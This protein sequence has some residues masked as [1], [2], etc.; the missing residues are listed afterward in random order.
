[1]GV[2]EIERPKR[3]AL[4][5]AVVFALAVFGV[6]RDAIGGGGDDGAD[7]RLQK[8]SVSLKQ[9]N[10]DDTDHAATAELGKAEALRDKAR[11]LM[12]ERRERDVLAQ[13]LDELEGTVSL[14]DAK[15]IAAKAKSARVAAEKKR[16]ELRAEVK[17]I[18]ADAD[19]LEAQQAELEKKLGGGK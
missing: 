1:M 6:G 15:I 13:T 2:H 12:G 7:A 19:K 14:I 9:Y 8:L 3:R 18:Q 4:A 11:S 16:D 10:V 5:T 17:K